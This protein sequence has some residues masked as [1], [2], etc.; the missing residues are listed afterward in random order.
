ML[1][2]SELYDKIYLNSMWNEICVGYTYNEN[3]KIHYSVSQPIHYNIIFIENV[4]KTTKNQ[5]YII[6]YYIRRDLIMINL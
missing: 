6:V 4:F 3:Q 5:R 1:Q 2:R